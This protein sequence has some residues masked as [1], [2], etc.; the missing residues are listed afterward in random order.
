[1]A[2]AAALALRHVAQTVVFSIL[3]T[4]S[5]ACVLF[6]R[7]PWKP[8][9]VVCGARERLSI[10]YRA[11]SSTPSLG[12]F[13]GLL[14][15]V[16]RLGI[17]QFLP[18]LRRLNISKTSDFWSLCASDSVWAARLEN[19]DPLRLPLRDF[20]RR[21]RLDHPVIDFSAGGSQSVALAAIVSEAGRQSVLNRADPRVVTR[22]TA[23]NQLALWRTLCSFAR[24][25]GLQP[26][27]PTVD[28][29]RKILATFL[30][31][32]YRTP[33]QYVSEARRRHTLALGQPPPADGDHDQGVRP[34]ASE[35]LARQ[36]VRTTSISR[37]SFRFRCS[38]RTLPSWSSP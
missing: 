2:C 10:P 11:M 27:P 34:L 3:T 35:A 13:E 33:D 17:V 29:V 7:C 22:G 32:H 16:Q 23:A 6:T 19:Q 18:E 5:C 21:A 8:V 37:S 38:G 25:W 12:T 24:A 4:L 20:D 15:L 28:G 26:I 30:A 9:P 1:M 31:G 36:R 14:Q